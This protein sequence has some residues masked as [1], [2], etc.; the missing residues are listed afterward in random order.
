[1]RS[2]KNNSTP[3]PSVAVRSLS[4]NR[5]KTTIMRAVPGDRSGIV[6][7]ATGDSCVFYATKRS[8]PFSNISARS[9]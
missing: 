3:V 9:V 1:M 7:S 4:S 2:E 6:V 5:I 8:S